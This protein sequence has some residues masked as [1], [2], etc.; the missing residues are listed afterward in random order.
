[1]IGI[2]NCLPFLLLK[3]ALQ[4]VSLELEV[5]ANRIPCAYTAQYNLG[6]VSLAQVV[7]VRPLMPAPELWISCDFQLGV[8]LLLL[9]F[10]RSLPSHVQNY[11]LPLQVVLLTAHIDHEDV[12]LFGCSEHHPALGH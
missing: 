12:V 2:L 5:M 10:D 1:M 8:L 7:P 11:L 6:T 3:I 9:S 4:V